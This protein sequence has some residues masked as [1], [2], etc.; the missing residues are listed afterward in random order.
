M[1]EYR[2]DRSSGTWVLIAPARGHRPVDDKSAPPAAANAPAY[3]PSCPFCPGNERMLPGVIADTAATG[4]PGWSARV[5]PNKYPALAGDPGTAVP[6]DAPTDD[7]MAGFGY[8][9]VVIETPKHNLDFVDLDA[10]ALKAVLLAYR[11][12]YVALAARPGIRSVIV[13]RNRGHGAGASLHH[14]HSQIIA[15]AM[16]PPRP[17][18]AADWARDRHHRTGQCPTCV[19]LDA[20]LADGSRL[21]ETSDRF[22]AFVPFA[23]S[24]PYEVRIAP[25]LHQTSFA[26][27]DD[28]ALVEF[29]ALLQRTIRRLDRLLGRRPYNFAIE[30]GIAPATDPASF[31]WRLRLLPNLTRPGGFELAAGLPINPALPEDD[32][33]ALR[34]SDAAAMFSGADP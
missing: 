28:D 33:A 30:S 23:A 25:R 21:I 27:A 10:D 3:D 15:T 18:A 26:D 2:Q 9:E 19:E 6:V 16:V 1:S 32:A 14:P 22:V 34:A 24:G 4:A 5:I 17:A 29:G 31:H 20:E 12:R 13:F 11:S 8:H 7:R